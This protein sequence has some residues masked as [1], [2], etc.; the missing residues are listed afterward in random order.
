MPADAAADAKAPAKAAS[1]PKVHTLE[2]ARAHVARQLAPAAPAVHAAAKNPGTHHHADPKHAAAAAA[3]PAG[4]NAQ[5]KTKDACMADNHSCCSPSVP[6]GIKHF[7]RDGAHRGGGGWM[8]DKSQWTMDT[9]YKIDAPQ[10]SAKPAAAHHK[11]K[12]P[13]GF[14]TQVECEKVNKMACCEPF[15]TFGIK[16]WHGKA[17]SVVKNGSKFDCGDRAPKWTLDAKY[18]PP[19]GSSHAAVL[20]AAP[21]PN[22]VNHKWQGKTVCAINGQNDRGCCPPDAKLGI[23]HWHGAGQHNFPKGGGK[24]YTCQDD[25][26]WNSPG[27]KKKVLNAPA[28]HH[29][30][31][32]PGVGMQGPGIDPGLRTH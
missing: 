3:K 4:S 25:L 8:C 28:K 10:S 9:N 6:L 32:V 17:E 20:A 29:H 22:N 19:D 5:F 12:N 30:R 31:V 24:K 16:S 26:T 13:A 23:K 18:K 1:G 15:S 11:V 14:K 7:Y 27:A 2:E 21:P